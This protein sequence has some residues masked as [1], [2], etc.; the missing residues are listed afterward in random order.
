MEHFLF[1]L[2]INLFFEVKMS[3]KEAEQTPI[4]SFLERVSDKTET[5]QIDDTD[6]VVILD[7]KKESN[8]RRYQRSKEKLLALRANQIHGCELVL[9]NIN[10]KLRKIQIQ[11]EKDYLNLIEDLLGTLKDNQML[12]DYLLTQ[13]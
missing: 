2:A 12:S 6:S 1:E 8:K 7:K 10:N 5:E 3:E 9:F 13:Y 4:S 11:S